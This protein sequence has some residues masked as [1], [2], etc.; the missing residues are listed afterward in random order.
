MRNKE[1]NI[2]LRSPLGRSTLEEEYAR[3][4]SDNRTGMGKSD[5]DRTRESAQRDDGWW[6]EEGNSTERARE[7]DCEEERRNEVNERARDG[8]RRYRVAVHG[9]REKR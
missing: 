6:N 7:V 9:A 1:R 3:A 8:R 2:A 5:C 4:R